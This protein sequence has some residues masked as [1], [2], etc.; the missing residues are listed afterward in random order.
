MVGK[1]IDLVAL[2]CIGVI[3][4]LSVS[5]AGAVKGLADNGLDTVGLDGTWIGTPLVWVIGVAP[6]QQMTAKVLAAPVH[7]FAPRPAEWLAPRGPARPP[8]GSYAAPNPPAGASL[9]YLLRERPSGPVELS[10]RD[11]EGLVVAR[12]PAPTAPGLHRI[13]WDLRSRLADGATETVSRGEHRIRLQV[14]GQIL[15]RR[16]EMRAAE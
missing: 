10:V 12:L 2:A 11:V 13:D 14:G 5:V 6:L 16:L 3:L 9:Y 15:T 4:I 8:P 1:A 7:L